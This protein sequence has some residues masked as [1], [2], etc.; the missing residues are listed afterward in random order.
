MSHL[1]S[2]GA[3]AIKVDSQLEK[4]IAAA[5]SVSEIQ[6]LLHSAACAQGLIQK[7]P[8]DRDG[9]DWFSHHVVTA[10]QPKSFAR[11]V[12]ANGVKHVVE[13][14]TEAELQANEL[15]LMR[16]LFGKT[17]AAAEQQR[18]SQGRFVA[19]PTPEEVEAEAI[20]L[21]SIDPTAAAMAPSVTAALEAAGIDVNALKEFT[22]AKQGE[23]IQT[24]WAQ[25][26]EVFR[27]SSAGASWPG[28]EENKNI[29]GQIIEDNHLLDAEDKV[30][31]LEAAYK[32]AVENDLLVEPAAERQARAINEAQTPE[33][34][35][36]ILR[37]Q[38]HLAPLGSN[39]WGR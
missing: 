34:L 36:E 16:Q 27:N 7:D 23:R 32:F 38:G 14:A 22:A 2:D 30:A 19:Q 18:D 21:S 12:V 15:A 4:D 9:T 1:M 25:A 3:S 28:G 20:R 26:G 13:G 5:S 33:Q 10:P 6:E 31:A 24:S 29:L 37:N 39:L 11:T 8:L 35:Q 17:D